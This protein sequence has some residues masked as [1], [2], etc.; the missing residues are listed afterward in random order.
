MDSKLIPWLLV[1][2]VAIW[3]FFIRRPVPAAAA[4]APTG[5]AGYPPGYVPPGLSPGQ[6]SP[7]PVTLGPQNDVVNYV[8]AGVGALGAVGGI[9]AGLGSIFGGSAKS[10]TLTGQ[11]PPIYA[12]AG[13]PS[14]GNGGY[15]DLDSGSDFGY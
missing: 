14:T 8:N 6:Y 9:I 7:G 13:G 15:E 10:G 5:Y 1:A 2:A 3:Y 12:G 4:T 11:S